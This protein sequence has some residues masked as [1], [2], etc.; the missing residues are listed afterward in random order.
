MLDNVRRKFILLEKVNQHS[1][2]NSLKVTII[3]FHWKMYHFSV[4][5]TYR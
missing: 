2:V 4:M 3:S 5:T 1:F